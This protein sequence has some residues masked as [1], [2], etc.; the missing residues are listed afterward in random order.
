MGIHVVERQRRRIDALGLPA[1][2]GIHRAQFLELVGRVGQ[3]APARGLA[4][5]ERP[6]FGYALAHANQYNKSLILTEF[7][8]FTGAP[9]TDTSPV[10]K[11]MAR[12]A[13][14]YLVPWSYWHYD[15]ESSYSMVKDA[16]QP[17]AG[18]NLYPNVINAVTRVYPRAIAGT[19][20]AWSYDPEGKI[21]SLTYDTARADGGGRFA[22]GGITEIF[23]P[24]QQFADG[25]GVEVTGG[26]VVS[27]AGSSLLKVTALPGADSVTVS[28]RP[29]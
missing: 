12:I 1:H 5:G 16:A 2:V 19:P 21:F 14:D 17:L 29:D 15:G 11:R 7:G 26:R 28:V 8:H 3:D 23:V 6:Q 25:Y 4:C 22:E 13:D 10:V 27:A 24:P 9:T 18:D 20:R